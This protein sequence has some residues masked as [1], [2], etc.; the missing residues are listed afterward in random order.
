MSTVSS[1]SFDVNDNKFELSEL[2]LAWVSAMRLPG[3]VYQSQS[4]Q[5]SD[6][7]RNYFELVVLG[8]LVSVSASLGLSHVANRPAARPQSVSQP[9]LTMRIVH[10]NSPAYM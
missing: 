9:W 5:Y 2:P 10:C 8:G 3:A 7:Q 6:T 4:K 1:G